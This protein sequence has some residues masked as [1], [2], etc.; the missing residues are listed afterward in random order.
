MFQKSVHVLKYNLKERK[1][2][3][4][5]SARKLPWGSLLSFLDIRG[6]KHAAKGQIFSIWPTGSLV[7]YWKLQAWSA[8]EFR[9]PGPQRTWSAAAA[10]RLV[11]TVQIQ[12]CTAVWM[13]PNC[14]FYWAYGPSPGEIPMA[15]I[16][17]GESVTTKWIN[18]R[19]GWFLRTL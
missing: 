13:W 17:P 18:G 10:P 14:S 15:Q 9:V 6:V 7:G 2:A 19:L 4:S 8:V 16:Q 11:L 3:R 5:A 12:L 1:Q